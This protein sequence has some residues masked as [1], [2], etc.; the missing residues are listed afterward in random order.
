M[1]RLSPDFSVLARPDSTH[2]FTRN[3]YMLNISSNMN[4][5]V[6]V[7]YVLLWLR[8]EFRIRIRIQLFT[9][10]R[11]R[12][13]LFTVLRS[14]SWW[15][16]WYESATTNKQTLQGAS[17]HPLWASTAL[18]RLHFEP[19]KLLNFDFNADPYPTFHSNADPDPR[20]CLRK[21]CNTQKICGSRALKML[22]S[23][24]TIRTIR[25][26]GPNPNSVPWY[27]RMK[28]IQPEWNC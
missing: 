26:K 15:S 3:N 8:P 1:S 24:P 27:L 22:N 11:I 9:V 13:R 10:M 5:S 19:L 16:K 7:Q 21:I 23:I 18:P 6:P 28:R 25:K 12:I 4:S 20:P 17:T 14:W 2:T